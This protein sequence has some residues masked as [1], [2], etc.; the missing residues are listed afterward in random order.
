MVIRLISNLTVCRSE[1]QFGYSPLPEVAK[2]SASS[3]YFFLQQHIFFPPVNIRLKYPDPAKFSA[4]APP[5]EY[6]AAKYS[7]YFMYR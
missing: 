6:S 5:Y 7:L 3:G 4:F 2:I 1:P